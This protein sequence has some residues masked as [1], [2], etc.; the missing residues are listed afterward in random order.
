VLKNAVCGRG[1]IEEKEGDKNIIIA[2]PW[3]FQKFS[4]GLKYQASFLMLILNLL[5]RG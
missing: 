3:L 4:E 5:G 2:L 1:H